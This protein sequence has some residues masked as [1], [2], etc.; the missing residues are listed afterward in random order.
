MEAEAQAGDEATAPTLTDEEIAARLEGLHCVW[1]DDS[2]DQLDGTAETDLNGVVERVV[3]R[4]LG[5][6]SNTT[7]PRLPAGA[8][9]AQAKPSSRQQREKPPSAAAPPRTRQPPAAAGARPIK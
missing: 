3:Q 9:P 6:S 1:H 8:F 7:T 4:S 5:I 2:Q